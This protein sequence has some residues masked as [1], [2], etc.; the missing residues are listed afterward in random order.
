MRL[1]GVVVLVA[2]AA[3]CT[4]QMT[5]PG[6]C[7]NFCPGGSITIRDTVLTAVIERDSTFL[8]YIRAH[9]AERMAVADS[10]GVIDSRAIFRMTQLPPTVPATSTDTVPITVDSALLRVAI[11]RR[12]TNATNLYLKIYRLPNTIDS[13][14]TFAQLQPNFSVRAVDSVNVSDLLARPAIVDTTRRTAVGNDTLRTDS[15]GHELRIL[16]DS[17]L[18][19]FFRLGTT[20]APFVAA[21]SGKIAWGVRVA[22]DSRAS[23]SLGTPVNGDLGDRDAL[24]TW[25]FHFTVP[26]TVSTEPDAVRDS[27][28]PRGTFFHSFVFDPPTPPVDDNLAVGGAPAARSLLRVAFPPFLRDSVDIARATLVLVPTAPVRGLPGDSFAVLARAVLTDL[29]A[30]SPLSPSTLVGQASIAIGTADTVRIEITDMFRT[31]A[32]DTTAATTLALSWLPDSKS[33]G[34]AIAGRAIEASS[35]TQIRFFS[36]RGA[37]RPALHV[38]YLKRFPFGTP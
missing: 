3:A 31:W 14:S 2:I 16:A 36:S 32:A 11:T 4:E 21:D 26:D 35:Y 24:L 17:S 22:A 20:Q 38:T 9:E 28:V 7:P 13:T 15:A 18:F 25:Y 34:K 10:P 12:D 1:S 33:A 5:A 6:N 30:K 37:M 23:V 27:T 29:G 8:G 19:L